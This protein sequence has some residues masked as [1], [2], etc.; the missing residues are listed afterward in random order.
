MKVSVGR[1]G[2]LRICAIASLLLL[3]AAFHARATHLRAGEITAVRENCSSL[4]YT[5]TITVYTN[6]RNTTVLFGGDGELLNFGDNEGVTFDEIENTIRLDLNPDGSV[7]TASFT[8]TH[9]YPGVGRYVISYREP[10]RNE[11]VLNMDASINTT[12]YLETE[13][14]VDPFLGCNNTP[15]LLVAP[16]DQACSGVTFTH[17]P[18][19]FDPDGDSLSY[20]LVVPFSDRNSEVINY[21]NPNDSKFYTNFETANEAGNGP[22]TFSI[23]AVDGTITWDAPGAIGEYNIAFHIIE[24][25]KKNGVYYRV[26]YVRRDM[27][28]L[29]DECDNE[30]PDLILPAD[31]CVVAGTTLDATILGIDPDNDDVK[32]EAFS[33]IFEF[34]VSESPATYTPVPDV[35]DFLPSP[36]ETKF[37]WE[38]ECIH[39]KDQPYQVVFKITD[40]PENGPKLVTFKTWFIRVVG[41]APAWEDAA[42]DLATRSTTLT[43]DPYFCQNAETM[44]VWRKVEGAAFEPDNC[45]TGMPE[46]LGYELI[47]T[48]PIKTSGTPVTTY[49][50]TNNGDGLAPGAR[51]CYRLV[52]TFPLPR[53]GESYVSVDTCVGPIL[54]DVPVITQVTVDRTD[55][56]E[57]QIRISWRQPFD[58]DP[59]QFPPPYRYEIYRAVGYTRGADSVNVS[60]P[61]EFTDTTFVDDAL[62]TLEN[63][64]NYSIAAYSSDGGFLGTSAAASSVR[65]DA[66]SEVKRIE[67]NW[68]AF[69]P[70]SNQ[71]QTF[72]NKHL[73]YRGPE[74]A[75]EADLVLIDSV[76]VSANGFVYVDEGQWN[77]TPLVD[78]ETYCYRIM[79][80][81]GYGNP[82]IG[83]PLE[84]FSQIVC[85]QPGD[86]IPPCKL[87][88]P[89]RSTLDY[90][91]CNEYYEKYCQKDNYSNIIFWSRAVDSSCRNDV[92]SYNV[93]ASSTKGGEFTLIAQNVR[94]TFYVDS[95]L[96]SFARCY[97]VAAVDVSGNVGELSEEMCID[98]CPYYELP[99]VFTPNDDDYN[100]FFSAYSIRGY[101][102]GEEGSC[103]PAE[104]RMKCARFVQSVTFTV[105]NRWGG[106]VYEYFGRTGSETNSIYIDWNGKDN[107]GTD[108]STGVYYYVAE[109]VFDSVDP[110]N[111]TRKF[112]GWVHLKL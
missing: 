13:L 54:A 56:S 71:I 88:P 41:P 40:N 34:P 53:G 70:W 95:N 44:Q 51:Y 109:V 39:V 105:Y 92:S 104:L 110:Q 90:T 112:K 57:G 65:V 31:T 14:S 23:N 6:T 97:K 2:F 46:F 68:S 48:L 63:V 62:N 30:R 111:N 5:I 83:Q 35:D 21:R 19:A 4:T 15:R 69:V 3:F 84:N 20:S 79:T 11:G 8:V 75:V 91:D 108:L 106:E 55:Q 66:N 9:T 74:G 26:G 103:I 32:I 89:L 61:G 28:I 25:R 24:W 101:D 86:T 82:A 64:Y 85:A 67:L 1:K 107:S 49:T 22:P 77:A 81:G 50:D 98:N 52:A 37:H 29:V 33:E 94:D 7:A 93:Y 36:A 45:Q 17:N 38:T 42:L 72:P 73:V 47:N 100:D 58:A 76:D 18:G 102:C 80:R 59:V 43:W 12:F 87:E 99:N 16:I 96:L 60:P 78:S 27:Q 10:N